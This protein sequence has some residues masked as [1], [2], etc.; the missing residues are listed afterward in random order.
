MAALIC[1]YGGLS[2]TGLITWMYTVRRIGYAGLFF[3]LTFLMV[4]LLFSFFS[5]GIDSPLVPWLGMAPLAGSLLLRNWQAWLLTGI[6]LLLLVVLYWLTP[7]FP[8]PLDYGFG[9]KMKTIALIAYS[10]YIL[11]CFGIVLTVELV[12]TDMA[13]LERITTAE[14]AAHAAGVRVLVESRDKERQRIARELH[15]HIGSVI[16]V[17]RLRHESLVGAG[18]LPEMGTPF[19]DRLESIGAR[20]GTVSKWFSLHILRDFGLLNGLR[21]LELEFRNGT[22]KAV[23]FILPEESSPALD[24]HAVQFYRI[25]QQILDGPAAHSPAEGI[26]LQ[27]LELPDQLRYMVEMQGEGLADWLAADAEWK[28]RLAEIR[29][30]TRVMEGEIL[31]ETSRTSGLTLIIETPLDHGED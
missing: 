25:T 24:A 29:D 19:F 7:Q 10:G 20:L 2:A 4:F 16:T 21:Y 18:S 11:F 12:R 1:L 15:D 17:V 13:R 8:D 30:R 22:G 28:F 6:S 31:Y 5:G 9:G 27:L 3:C 23:D 26:T 14:S